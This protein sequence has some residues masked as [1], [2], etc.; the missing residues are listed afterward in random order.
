VAEIRNLVNVPLE[1]ATGVFANS[2]MVTFHGLHDE[3]EHL[4]IVLGEFDEVV[5]RSTVL[6]RLHSECLTGDV[7]GSG[8]CDCGSQLREA[9]VMLHAAG[10]VIL[11][12]RQE[13]RGIGLYNKLDAYQMQELGMDTFEANRALR[14]GDDERDYTVAVQMLYALG[15][16]E[17][18]LLSNNPAKIRQL[19][20]GGINVNS[21]RP[22]GVHLTSANR[23]YLQAKVDRAGHLINLDLD[24]ERRHDSS[25]Q[26]N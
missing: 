22:T 16:S 17:I 12:L 11:Y 24:L 4:A 19:S 26:P 1:V 6:V 23:G 8:R 5:A 13:G 3:R 20:D 15:I 2:T 7:F 21:R 25:Q 14:F 10:G 9:L 18:D